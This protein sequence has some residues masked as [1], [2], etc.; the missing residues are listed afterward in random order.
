MGGWQASFLY[1]PVDRPVCPR[2]SAAA[3]LR[4]RETSVK[5]NGWVEVQVGNIY[6]ISGLVM[7]GEGGVLVAKLTARREWSLSRA[8]VGGTV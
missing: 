1:S 2:G 8:D 7:E 4:A 6:R 3:V 5:N